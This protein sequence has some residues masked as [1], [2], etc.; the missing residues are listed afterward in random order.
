[1]NEA[2]LSL[3]DSSLEEGLLRQSAAINVIVAYCNVE[4][5]ET[6]RIQRNAGVPLVLPYWWC[7]DASKLV[8]FRCFDDGR[9]VTRSGSTRA[10]TRYA[11]FLG[12]GL[13]FTI[14]RSCR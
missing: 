13:A 14:N 7:Y 11:V 6:C 4:E 1:M 8:G 12:A 9:L 2:V 10:Q 3:P 5:G